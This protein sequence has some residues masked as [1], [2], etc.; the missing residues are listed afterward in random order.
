MVA[1]PSCSIPQIF[2]RGFPDSSGRSL[3][4][5]SQRLVKPQVS[6][7]LI[8]AYFKEGDFVKAGA[9]L[10]E[11]DRRSLEAQ[12][13][14]AQANIQRSEAM[15]RQAQANVAKSRAQLQYLRD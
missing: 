1:N 15:T 11:I 12:V 9:L 6:G 13:A 4:R 14:Q 3:V 5:A 7:E 8:K 10:F 2:M